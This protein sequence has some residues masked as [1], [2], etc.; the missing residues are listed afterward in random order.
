MPTVFPA[1]NPVVGIVGS[2][3]T[4]PVHRIYCVG[5]NY[6]D[7]AREMGANPDREPPF[8]FCKPADAVNNTAVIPYPSRT[9]DL[10]H[11]IELVVAIGKEGKE[12]PVEKA[13]DLIYG[14]A[15]GL[16]LTRRDL[17]AQAKQ[18]S[19]PWDTAKGFDNS[20]P[21]SNI[22]PLKQT[23]FITQGSISLAVNDEIKQ[24]GDLAD[25]IWSVDEVIAEL[26]SLFLLCPG[27]LIYTGTPAGV[28]RLQKDDELV[29]KIAGLEDLKI[30]VA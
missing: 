18:Q 17:Q 14:Y 5:R 1:S 27:D 10:H 4:F 23:G 30:R 26:S 20:A 28:G 11:E 7:H 29:G 13:K 6:A 16:D 3:D 24:Q 12:I 9:Q 21:I 8:F 19:R 2:N 25:M 22:K 15:V